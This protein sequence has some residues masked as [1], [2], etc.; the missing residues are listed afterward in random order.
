MRRR[1][2]LLAAL[3]LYPAAALASGKKAEP[4]EGEG[5]T[6]LPIAA[7]NTSVTNPYGN[8]TVLTVGVG[9]DA[10]DPALRERASLMMPRLRSAYLETL[11]TYGSALLPGAAPN[12][13]LLAQRLQR[14][15]D[16]LLGKTG[17]RLL[18][19]AVVV[20]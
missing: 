15:T 19:G 18:L 20:N 8:R 12:A 11:Q 16:R 14:D 7:I 6:Y 17:A 9:L 5:D 4:K 3:A 10:P 1:D 13:D 2:L